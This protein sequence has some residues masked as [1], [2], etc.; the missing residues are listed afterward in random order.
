MILLN[1]VRAKGTLIY[2]DPI[3][4]EFPQ[5]IVPILGENRSWESGSNN[6]AGK[7]TLLNLVSI[8]LWGRVPS[9][10]TK[11][12]LITYGEKA[13]AVELELGNLTVKRSKTRGKG[14]KLVV[15]YEGMVHGS[16]IDSKNSETVRETQKV[17][18][19]YLGMDFNTFC[20]SV[21]LGASSKTVKILNCEPGPRAKLVASL[22]TTDVYDRAL[23]IVKVDEKKVVQ[24]KSRN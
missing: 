12:A 5:G 9:G 21:Y 8:A 20:N 17:L 2:K 11:D 23:E 13:Y 24:E 6:G 18:E 4:I 22:V 1:K 10:E 19:N 14:E 3:E 15:L 16:K 7:T